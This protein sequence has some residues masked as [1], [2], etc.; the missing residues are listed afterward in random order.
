M[1]VVLYG[2]WVGVQGFRVQVLW[3]LSRNLRE[4]A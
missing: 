2:V 3:S 1:F 4:V